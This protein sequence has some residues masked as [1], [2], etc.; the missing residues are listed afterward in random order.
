MEQTED[1]VASQSGARPEELLADGMLA[2]IAGSDTTA[3]MLSHLFYFM[4]RHPQCAERLRKE[5]AATFPH[6][7]DPI[8]FARLGEMPYLNA[9]M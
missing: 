4:L 7:E 1:E 2:I 9:C 6:D 5:L 8:N 3:T